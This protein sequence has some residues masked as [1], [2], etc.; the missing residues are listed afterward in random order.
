VPVV[1]E[2]EPF[3]LGLMQIAS[4]S[5]S[6]CTRRSLAIGGGD[7][8]YLDFADVLGDVET[9]A[10]IVFQRPLAVDHRHGRPPSR[11]PVG[12]QP[13][14]AG[15]VVQ[16]TGSDTAVSRRRTT[17]QHVG[18]GQQLHATTFATNTGMVNRVGF[19]WPSTSLVD[20]RGSYR[21]FARARGSG[22]GTVND[23]HLQR[24]RTGKSARPAT[25]GPF[26]VD[27]G[28]IDV[29]QGTD[30][31]YNGYS[32]RQW[33]SRRALCGCRLPGP[34]RRRSTWTTST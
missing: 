8:R 13:L 31:V 29:P 10:Q 1:I 21:V 33:L 6:R 15:R 2:A 28:V 20:A 14:A 5:R 3:G 34:R 25:T 7:G 26:V 24:H 17:Q 30:P 32:N 9:P 11:H 23:R 27:L 22:T 4:G 16:Q 19:Q 18:D 12:G